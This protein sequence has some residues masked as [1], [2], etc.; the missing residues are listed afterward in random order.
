[1]SILRLPVE[2]TAFLVELLDV[3]SIFNLGQGCRQLSYIL[4]DRRMCRLALEK[5]AFSAEA[6]EAQAT[7]EYARQFRRLAKRRIAVRSGQPWT[8][9]IVAMADRFIYT[10]RTLCY[11]VNSGHLR[12]LSLARAPREEFVVNVPRLLQQAVRDFDPCLS[13]T[14]EPLYYAEGILSCMAT[15]FIDQTT[16][17]WLVI[18]ELRKNVSWVVVKRPCSDHQLFVRNDKNY[19]F[20]GIKSHVRIDG[21]Y[22]WGLH[23]LD[24]KTRKWE[25][26]P[27]ILWEYDGSS[28]GSDI[29]FE[30]IDGYFYCVSNKK[31]TPTDHEI[32]NCFYRVVRFSVSEATHESCHTLPMRNLWR[33]HDS[34]GVV[35][36]RWTSLQI[37]KDEVT[38]KLFI[39]ETRR[40]WSL[41][42]AGSQRTCY[43][44][45]LRFDGGGGD[46]LNPRPELSLP[47]PPASAG[48]NQLDLNWDR[49]SHVEERPG[50]NV[51]L[52]DNPTDDTTYTLQECFIRSYNP[53]CDSFIDLVCESYNP[54]SFLQLRVR[55]KTHLFHQETEDQ[56]SW[57]QRR[58]KQAVHLW[59]RD[60]AQLND[61]SAQLHD[62]IDPVKPMK[63]V[64]WGM[65]E[66]NL[67]YSPTHMAPGQLRP[68]VLLSF[69]PGL[70]FP[71]FSKFPCR[72]AGDSCTSATLSHPPPSSGELGCGIPEHVVLP[73][74]CH[75]SAE[76]TSTEER[77]ESGSCDF[78]KLC[79]PL[80]QSMGMGNG[81][82][83]GFDMSYS[84]CPVSKPLA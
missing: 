26:S 46:R 59:P 28:I 5:A 65:D 33:R 39:V 60:S 16:I 53:S 74:T 2:I 20:C 17:R 6:R 58:T 25:D 12:I 18:F 75:D 79:T 67:V 51:H 7:K 83:H 24:L 27:L 36:E 64:D 45:E 31:K 73:T 62:I 76:C 13:Y 57:I 10:N 14:F 37:T 22:R 54:D 30:I 38:D 78:V 40:E 1:M 9:A 71:G 23:R 56:S 52:G 47:T 69:D 15:Q 43:K 8:V 34:E 11:T 48:R 41:K 29:C 61:I 68:V 80:Y 84:T 21:S 55:S 81:T 50:D 4:Y 77:D 3:E 44:K 49:E 42:Y 66:R 19:L 63:G 70:H 72:P 82:P 32:Q 35:D